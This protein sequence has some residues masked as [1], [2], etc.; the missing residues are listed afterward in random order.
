MCAGSGATACSAPVRRSQ[1]LSSPEEEASAKP[2]APTHRSKSGLLLLDRVLL[3][4]L[5]LSLLGVLTFRHD[6]PSLSLSM[7]VWLLCFL[8]NPYSA[9]RFTE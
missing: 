6:F 4:L 1:S 8:P 2:T 7:W 9:P 5:D 3:R